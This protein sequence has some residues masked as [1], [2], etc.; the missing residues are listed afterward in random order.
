MKNHRHRAYVSP[1][2][3]TFC[4]Y[5]LTKIALLTLK[6]S[7]FKLAVEIIEPSFNS[8]SRA[9]VQKLKPTAYF[10]RLS[11]KASFLQIQCINTY[12]HASY[13][14]KCNVKIFIR[15]MCKSTRAMC[16]LSYK[17]SIQIHYY[18]AMGA[19]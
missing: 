8:F 13:K 6:K 12:N 3:S 16:S 17:E 15:A 4:S 2:Q 14:F 18:N 9:S 19:D 7:C 1:S 11:V 10:I 5:R